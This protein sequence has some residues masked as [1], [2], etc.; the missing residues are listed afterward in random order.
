[1]GL[2]T[3]RA[4]DSWQHQIEASLTCAAGLPPKAAVDVGA[5]DRVAAVY[6]MRIPPYWLALMR[7]PGDPFF[8]QAVPSAAELAPDNFEE[9]PFGEETASPAPGVV[10]R[11][12]NRVLLL[13]TRR[14]AMYC[15]HCMRKRRSGARPDAAGFDERQAGEY[16][17]SRPDIREVILSGGDP[18]MLD[19]G[20]LA[21]ILAGVGKAPNVDIRR[22]HT[23]MPCS[24][25]QR[26]TGSL[27]RCLRR[28]GPLIVVTQFNHPAELT[29]AAAAAC[30]RLVDAGIP[31]LCQTVLLHG[32]NDDAGTLGRLM[33][34]LLTLRVMPYYLHHPDPVRGTAHFGLTVN[35]GLEIYG[36]LRH[37]VSGIGLPRYVRDDRGAVGK[38]PLTEVHA[39][40]DNGP[41]TGF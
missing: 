11:Y 41:A 26:I 28:H 21:C 25:P 10:H 8:M 35:R 4:M 18:L 34:G 20:R 9:D 16:I 30:A 23:R 15:R 13:V 7:D 24:L 5:V 14:C 27:V 19:D 12:P 37:H 40:G 3:E 1:M 32:I 2:L 39:A 17:R 36:A 29:P 22:I 31:V 38:M 6:P 33:R